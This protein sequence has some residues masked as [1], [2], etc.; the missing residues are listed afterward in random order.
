MSAF[1]TNT[2]ILATVLP[3]G[4]RAVYEISEQHLNTRSYSGQTCHGRLIEQGRLLA[5]K[6]GGN[7]Y[8][9]LPGRASWVERITDQKS[10]VLLDS[11]PLAD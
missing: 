4:N 5:V 8:N 2:V 3:S 7:W 9:R 10:I 11:Y 6:D 1:E